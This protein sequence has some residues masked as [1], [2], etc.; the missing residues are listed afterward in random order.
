MK[1]PDLIWSIFRIL[2]SAALTA[3]ALALSLGI[4]FFAWRLTGANLWIGVLAAFC[5]L[6]FVVIPLRLWWV[7]KTS[8]RK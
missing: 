6:L 8:C 2:S 3:S 4:G 7:M 1:L 5:F